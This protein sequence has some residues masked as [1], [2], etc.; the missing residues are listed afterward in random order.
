MNNEI[1]LKNSNSNNSFHFNNNQDIIAKRKN[2]TKSMTIIHN[3][4]MDLWYFKN[5]ILKD[6][7]NF[8]KNLTDKYNKGD[9]E[10]KEEILNINNNINSIKEKINELSSLIITDNIVKEKVDNLEKI[11]NKNFDRI[12]T[13]EIKVNNIEK[14]TKESIIRVNNIL[15]ETVIY[16]GL[17]GPSCKFNSFHDLIDYILNELFLLDTFKEKNIMDLST[18]K[19]KLESI[20]NGFKLKIDNINKA[21]YQFTL[22][23]FGICDEKIKDFKEKFDKITTNFENNFQNFNSKFEELFKDISEL[24][25][26]NINNVNNFNEHIEKFLILK[27]NYRKI[28]D[29]INQKNFLLN[30]RNNIFKRLDSKKAFE[31]NFDNINKNKIKKMNSSLKSE[32]IEELKNNKLN[33]IN[34]IQPNNNFNDS[35]EMNFQKPNNISDKNINDWEKMKNNNPI[36]SNN[37]PKFNIKIKIDNSNL[38]S[39][40]EKVSEKSMDNMLKQVSNGNLTFYGRK[41]NNNLL[42]SDLEDNENK[43]NQ[44]P[45]I[46]SNKIKNLNKLYMKNGKILDIS[47]SQNSINSKISQ[48]INEINNIEEDIKNEEIERQ[49]IKIKNKN[50]FNRQIK[51]SNDNNNIWLSDLNKYKTI[52][53]ANS[54]IKDKFLNM[55]NKLSSSKYKN[56]I[57]TLEGS[58]KLVIDSKDLE[59]GKNIYHIESLNNSKKDK[60]MNSNERLISSKPY[61]IDKKTFK[62]YNDIPYSPKDDFASQVNF[63]NA[64]IIYLNKSESHKILMK[65]KVRNLFI[66]NKNINSKDFEPTFNLTHYSPLNTNKVINID[67]KIYQKIK[68]KNST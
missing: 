43:K 34:E 15:R 22:E 6:L 28:Y 16:N 65:N 7:K 56:I 24:K 12:L 64:K 36:N 13:N 11:N 39:K 37:N 26:D 21:S 42:L 35:D 58:K 41:T 14:E 51:K 59:N 40:L 18:Y 50:I 61:L 8:E 62:L 10:I 46:I 2:D 68:G 67:E 17:I 55:K 45:N 1:N 60:K 54:N 44:S 32:L 5:D 53:S 4:K 52:N 30:R 23:N 48:K 31:E 33:I 29:I 47:N 63:K 66:E 25:N 57:L 38:S 20:I 19:K 9:I 3:S 49:T 27:E